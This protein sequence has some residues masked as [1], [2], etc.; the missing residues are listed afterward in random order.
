MEKKT[1]HRKYVM[2][3]LE[4]RFLQ[5]AYEEANRRRLASEAVG[6]HNAPSPKRSVREQ[7]DEAKCK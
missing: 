1:S 6:I 2:S 5:E 4:K 7:T 3:A